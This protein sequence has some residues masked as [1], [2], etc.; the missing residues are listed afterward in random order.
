MGRLGALGMMFGGATGAAL[1]TA[2]DNNQNTRQRLEMQKLEDESYEKIQ[3][4]LDKILSQPRYITRYEVD[5]SENPIPKSFFFHG[6]AF[7]DMFEE[8]IT[9]FSRTFKDSKLYTK[10][11]NRVYLHN[12][13]F[14]LDFIVVGNEHQT[15]SKKLVLFEPKYTNKNKLE[16]DVRLEVD[17]FKLKYLGFSKSMPIKEIN[18]TKDP[19]EILIK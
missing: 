8:R 4:D 11:T 5:V 13:K 15:E 9:Y 3:K 17:V 16:G 12:G 6:F 19:D 7:P 2:L 1:G 14:W 18:P 10:E